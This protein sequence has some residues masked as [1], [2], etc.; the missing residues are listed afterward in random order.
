MGTGGVAP[1]QP[2]GYRLTIGFAHY[3][4]YLLT[5]VSLSP[6]LAATPNSTERAGFEPALASSVA[7]SLGV[8]MILRTS[9]PI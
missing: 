3:S 1:P 4:G 2:Y 9:S 7:Y 6:A 5:V 8:R